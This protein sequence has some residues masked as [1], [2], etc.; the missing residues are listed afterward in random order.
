MCL[1]PFK[2]FLKFFLH[3]YVSVP[4][5]VCTCVLCVYELS[6]IYIHMYVGI[7]SPG[8]RVTGSY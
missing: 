5:Y 7:R 6:I 8:T 1:L 3:V 2:D 4:M